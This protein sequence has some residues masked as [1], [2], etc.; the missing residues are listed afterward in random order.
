M[1]ANTIRL[2]R[3]CWS[4]SGVP[5]RNDGIGQRVDER[6]QELVLVADARDLVIGVEH[7]A[8]VEPQALDD[9]LVGVG[10]DRL[11]ERLA[12]QVLPA[13]RRG[14]VAVGAEHDVVRRQ[15]VRRDEE[16]E[17]A[18]DEAPLVL[19]QPV[20]VLPQRDV[21]AHLDFLR[22]PVIGARG[23]VLLPRPLVLERHQLV[24]VGLA[25]DDALVGDVD[26]PQFRRRFRRRA[27]GGWRNPFG[28]NVVTASP[29]GT[30]ARRLVAP[31]CCS[32][33][34]LLYCYGRRA[35]D[36]FTESSVGSARRSLVNLHRLLSSSVRIV[37]ALL[38]RFA[39]GVVDRAELRVGRRR[40]VVA[41]RA[42]RS[43]GSS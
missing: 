6:D 3:S 34:S 17:V 29:A 25:V 22:H 18:L 36:T 16:A 28:G 4:V 26:A 1:H 41:R 14:D 7:L 30:T 38:A 42:P 33:V 32:I 9:V 13:L 39:L 15:R 35:R 24:D 43:T 27:A 31:C 37:P 20:R 12:Q 2:F 5:V 11:L 40:A 10:V 21:A 8:L 19:G 23:E